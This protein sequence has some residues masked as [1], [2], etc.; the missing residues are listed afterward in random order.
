MEFKENL[1]KYQEIINFE[2]KN[3]LPQEDSMEKELYIAMEYSLLAGGKRIR[4]IL[5]LATY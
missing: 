1:K 3:S 4:P 2:L 5:L